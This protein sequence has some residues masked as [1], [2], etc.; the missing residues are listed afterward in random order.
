MQWV[1]VGP[2]ALSLTLA[3]HVYLA[4]EELFGVHEL[5]R[6]AYSGRDPFAFCQ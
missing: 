4:Q 5:V 2:D 6:V 1:G 3:G